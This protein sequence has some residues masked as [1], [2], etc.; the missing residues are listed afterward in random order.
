MTV[1][2]GFRARQHIIYIVKIVA[3][4]LTSDRNNEFHDGSKDVLL[5]EILM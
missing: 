4:S 5:H 2:G 3:L 1:N